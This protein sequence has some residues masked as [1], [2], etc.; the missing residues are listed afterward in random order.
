MKTRAIQHTRNDKVFLFINTLLLT[1]FL[2]II[3]YPLWLVV[4]SS[5]SDPTA[6]TAGKVVILP[7]GFSLKGY[8]A[9]AKYPMIV[10]GFLNSFILMVLG[11]IS[12]IIVTLL[13]GYPLSRNDLPGK[14]G[15]IV[16]LTFTMYF[17]GGLIP[18][19]LLMKSLGLI[20]TLAAL[21]VP[22]SISVWNMI[23]VKTYFQTS[24][25][26]EIFQAARVDG[27]TDFGYLLRIGIPLAKPIIAVLSLFTAVG[28]WNSYFGALIYLNDTDLFPLQ[29]VLRD[30]LIVNATNTTE[31]AQDVETIKKQQELVALLK[32]SVIVAA[33][34]PLLIMYPFVQKYFV[35]GI[36]VGSLKG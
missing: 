8:A 23:L 6:V 7:I 5:I 13:G 18:S 36:L 25:P 12:C 3:F 20:N 32:Y 28:M 10:R 24:V 17:S 31:F 14:K 27:C 35:K 26:D 16:I 9:I 34:A 19:F 2:I 29:L 21:I 15:I 30:I 4:I 1:I 33:S 22:G 11:T